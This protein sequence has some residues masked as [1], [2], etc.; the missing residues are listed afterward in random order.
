MYVYRDIPSFIAFGVSF[1]MLLYGSYIDWKFREID[2]WPW[3]VMALTGVFIII[4]IDGNTIVELSHILPFISALLSLFGPIIDW[5]EIIK[6]D[7]LYYILIDYGSYVISAILFLLT[8]IFLGLNN[9]FIT[10]LIVYMMYVFIRVLY[11]LSVIHGGA[12]AKALMSISFLFFNGFSLPV[13][14]LIKY[15][16]VFPFSFQVL[17]DA[18]LISLFLPVYFFIINIKNRNISI[19]YMLFGYKMSLPEAK[20]KYVWLM[21]LPGNRMIL[22]P[23]KLDDEV[24]KHAFDGLEREK[25]ENV[26]VTPQLPFIIFIFV[27][28][29]IQTIFFSPLALIFYH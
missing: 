3:V 26:W 29:I 10:M 4:Y 18:V 27:G 23:G 8:Y 2:N 13:I 7:D 17:F 21:E 19:P 25:K 24:I 15:N 16:T 14:P 5:D 22:F 20:K 1:I 28:F 9:F 6:M 11:E 12:D